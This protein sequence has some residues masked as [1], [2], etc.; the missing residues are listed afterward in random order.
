MATN[1]A[2]RSL[3]KDGMRNA[4]FAVALCALAATA[5]IAAGDRWS[6]ETEH[7]SRTVKLEPGGNLRV[8]S[9]SGRG[10]IQIRQKS[11]SA[12]Q[13]IDVQ[14]FSG[15]IDLHVP[16]A[17]RATVSFNSF[18]GHL[19]SEV[20]LTIRT[21][22]RSALKGE[23]GGGGGAELRFKTFSGSVRIDR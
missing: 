19:D 10:P 22:N 11:F 3:V 13:T 1:N 14:T 20:P 18:S 15:S 12:S 7:I 9:F 6:D 4:V 5:V 8:K 23:L 2:A 16:E 17:T 21:G